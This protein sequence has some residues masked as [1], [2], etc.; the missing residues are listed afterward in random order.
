MHIKVKL[1]I[2]VHVDNVGAIFMTNN[3]TTSGHM[4]HVDVCYKFVTMYV[5]DGFIKIIFVKL[6]V[7]DSDIMTKNWDQIFIPNMLVRWFLQR[8]SSKGVLI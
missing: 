7:N 4:K 2:I 5:E 8:T 3:V 1:P 6:S